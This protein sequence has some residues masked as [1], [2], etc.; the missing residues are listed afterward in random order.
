MY[1][2]A[3]SHTYLEGPSSDRDVLLHAVQLCS[4][5]LASLAS[6]SKLLIATFILVARG[7]KG[8]VISRYSNNII[9]G[10]INSTINSTINVMYA[11]NTFLV[12]GCWFRVKYLKPTDLWTL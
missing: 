6:S 2:D 7:Q 11:G 4:Q 5:S 1:G 12:H 3:G 9:V 8:V 10:S